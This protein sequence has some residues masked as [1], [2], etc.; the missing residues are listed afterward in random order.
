MDDILTGF[1]A[2]SR[3][4]Q[5]ATGRVDVID[6]MTSVIGWGRSTPRVVV[7]VA[8]YHEWTRRDVKVGARLGFDSVRSKPSVVNP[9]S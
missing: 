3:P 8:V 1:P 9:A 4:G 6:W 7:V 5:S 2:D